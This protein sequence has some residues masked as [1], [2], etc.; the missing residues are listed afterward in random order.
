MNE[1]NWN[2]IL[3]RPYLDQQ[4]PEARSDTVGWCEP[5][6][7][8]S[9]KLQNAG[10]SFFAFEIWSLEQIGIAHYDICL[11]KSCVI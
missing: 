4:Q 1:K 2:A 10:E 3:A 5:N 8:K 7:Q 6:D 9:Q 11:H